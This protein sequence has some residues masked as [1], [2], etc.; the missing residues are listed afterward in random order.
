MRVH[1]KRN[2]QWNNRGNVYSVPKPTHGSSNG[3]LPPKGSNVGGKGGWGRELMLTEDQ[4]EYTRKGEEIKRERRTLWMMTYYQVSSQE[5]G[6]AG[7]ARSRW[8]VDG[9]SIPS[10]DVRA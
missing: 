10:A 2:Y 1:L 4:K 6:L 9:T 7:R 3:R 5:T 8:E